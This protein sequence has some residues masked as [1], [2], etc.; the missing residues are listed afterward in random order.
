MNKQHIPPNPDENR[1]EELLRKIQPLPGENF[2]EKMQQT[3]WRVDGRK[4][5]GIKSFRLKIAFAVVFLAVLAILF[6]TPPGQA[7]AQEVFQFF[8]RINSSTIELPERDLKQM[9]ELPGQYDLP[10]VPVIIPAVSP[11]MAALPGCDTPEA[12]QSYGCQVAL[13]E[14]QLGFDLKELPAQPEGWRFDAV[15]FATTSRSATI[16]YSLDS[17]QPSYGTFYLR[18]GEGIFSEVYPN[19]PWS[20]VPADKVEKVKVGMYDGE[21]VRGSFSLPANGSRLVWSDT[22]RHS[23]LAWSDGTRWFLIELWPNLNLP[24]RLDRDRLIE[25]AE[26]LVDA[27]PEQ[28]ETLD[29]D[30]LA[31]VSDAEKVSGFD[32]KAPTLLP[33]G[34]SFSYARFYPNNAEVRLFYGINNELVIYQWK[35]RSLDL[36]TLPKSYDPN[37]SQEF[38]KVHG[39][40]A[41]YG[42]GEGP[43]PY[44]FLWWEEEDV[45]YQMYHYNMIGGSLSKDK[46]IAI[47]ESM[48]D[49]NDF[50][51]KDYPYEY[52]QIYAQALGFDAREFPATPHGWSYASVWPLP[53]DGCIILAYRSTT[54]Q[55]SLYISQ[56]LTAKLSDISGVPARFIEQVQIGDQPGQY[57]A[58]EFVSGDQGESVWN[59]DAPVKQLYWQEDNLW[60]QVT[61]TM[62]YDKVELIA[63]AES[64]R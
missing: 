58:G 23:R 48:Q 5:P 42:S 13:A 19:D 33:M 49:F 44:L 2:H 10:L 62:R 47:A 29:P 57:I 55:G 25:L 20:L 31:S 34:T 14:S 63:I 43:E 27:P 64:L 1:I 38:V 9:Q 17:Q 37:L 56:C 18:Q 50:R 4:Q 46:M 21:Y 24:D 6:V 3:A 22:D 30:F 40:N 11:E 16:G 61:S 53:S 59:P 28:A 8:N 32:L 54:E 52:V 35:E 12:A 15:R 41:L 7:W 39:R 51:I 26:R 60:M 36:N 45:Y